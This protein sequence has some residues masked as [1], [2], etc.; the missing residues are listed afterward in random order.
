M[1]ALGIDGH[2]T[3]SAFAAIAATGDREKA[4]AALPTLSA[5]CLGCHFSY[6]I[7]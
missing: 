5:A 6:R 1:H 4:L 3:A 7:R 2:K